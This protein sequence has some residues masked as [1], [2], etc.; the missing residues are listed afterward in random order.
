MI[1]NQITAAEPATAGGKDQESGEE[2]LR[3]YLA[4][5]VR[6][7]N[8]R[9][10]RLEARITALAHSLGVHA[11][12]ERRD[13][14]AIVEKELQAGGIK[15]FKNHWRGILAISILVPA[16]TIAITIGVVHMIGNNFG[17][18]PTA[19]RPYAR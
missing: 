18:N 2:R 17:Q 16:V 19:L 3:A 12:N 10:D 15:Y 1:Q 9:F 13:A 14:D 6:Q 5:Y 4:E 11:P 8:E 7:S